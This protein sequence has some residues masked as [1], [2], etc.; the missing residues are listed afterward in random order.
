M[1]SSSRRNMTAFTRATPMTEQFFG[2]FQ[3]SRQA[4]QL[5]TTAV[6]ARSRRKLGSPPR[7]LSILTPDR[8]GQFMPWR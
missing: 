2:T 3:S 8:T 5:P 1:L 6:A 7:R 4:R